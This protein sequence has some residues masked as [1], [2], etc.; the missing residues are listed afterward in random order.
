MDFS[1]TAWIYLANTWK[2]RGHQGEARVGVYTEVADQHLG[3]PPLTALDVS[4]RSCLA[5]SM[6]GAL[7]LGHTAHCRYLREGHKVA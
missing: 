2:V 5:G 6:L 3:L 4:D 7:T 1:N